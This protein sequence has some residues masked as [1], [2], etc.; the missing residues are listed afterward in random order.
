MLLT[1]LPNLGMGGSDAD[2]PAAA[3][4]IRGTHTRLAYT[5]TRRRPYRIAIPRFVYGR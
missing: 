1:L 4:V 3:A 5:H 2:A